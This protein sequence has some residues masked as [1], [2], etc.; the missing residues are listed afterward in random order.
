ME[1]PGVQSDKA[2]HQVVPEGETSQARH[3][4]HGRHDCLGGYEALPTTAHTRIPG[5]CTRPAITA[6]TCPKA[7]CSSSS[8]GTANPLR[9]GTV[10]Y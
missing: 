9:A 5:A 3:K 6:P 1:S 4:R 7:V 8:H 10:P 2:G